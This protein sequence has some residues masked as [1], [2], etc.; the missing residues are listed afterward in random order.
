MRFT[1]R[2]NGLV[3]RC[4][5]LCR[6]HGTRADGVEELT[7]S[8]Y[9]LIEVFGRLTGRWVVLN[10]SF[11]LHG[12]PIVGGA[13]D[14]IDVFLKSGLDDL[15]VDRWLIRKRETRTVG[16]P[17]SGPSRGELSDQSQH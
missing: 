11:N 4:R 15:V 8:F 7:P 2:N 10:T 14:A 1:P 12:F 9:R 5:S 13:C 16:S 3:G 17:A 6:C